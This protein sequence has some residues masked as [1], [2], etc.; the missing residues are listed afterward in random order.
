MQGVSNN[1]DIDIFHNL[2]SGCKQIFPEAMGSDDSLKVIAD[3]IRSCAFLI[4][5]GVS[6]SNEGRGLCASKD[7]TES[8]K[9]W[10]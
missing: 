6:P 5:D 4:A 7:Y 9:T 8:D 3:H 10:A 1:Y 2:I